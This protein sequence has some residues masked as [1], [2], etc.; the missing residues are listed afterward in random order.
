MGVFMNKIFR[1]VIDEL[2]Q[3]LAI[4]IINPDN[5]SKFRNSYIRTLKYVLINDGSFNFPV[6][7]DFYKD[8]EEMLT[9]CDL[10][11]Y[12]RGSVVT[13][14]LENNLPLADSEPYTYIQANKYKDSIEK[15]GIGLKEFPELY[16]E[17]L[18]TGSIS[19]D[20]IQNIARCKKYLDTIFFPDK[21]DEKKF[22]T[23]YKEQGV[24]YPKDL[25]KDFVKIIYDNGKSCENSSDSQLYQDCYKGL[26]DILYSIGCPSKE[27]SDKMLY[28]YFQDNSLTQYTEEIKNNIIKVFDSIKIPEEKHRLEEA[29]F[30]LKLKKYLTKTDMTEEEYIQFKN[31]LCSRF[32]ES[33]SLDVVGYFKVKNRKKVNNKPLFVNPVVTKKQVVEEPKVS[34]KQLKKDFKDLY[35]EKEICEVGFDFKNYKRLLELLKD[36]NYADSVNQ[37]IFARIYNF[38]QKNDDY[39]NVLY[40]RARLLGKSSVVDEILEI[41]E[42]LGEI[43][44]RERAMWLDQIRC[45]ETEITPLYEHDFDYEFHLMREMRKH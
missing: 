7:I 33:L 15:A 2:E 24:S 16:F 45:L 11:G 31:L 1:K 5:T 19:S 4:N 44:P 27:L 38:A 25:I 34:R 8:L 29:D 10:S 3:M 30:Y 35:D 22:A 37:E 17:Y 36:L 41:Q 12:E 23:F 28:Q 32:S 39:Y 13:R 42:L 26:I 6:I 43:P 9:C 14:I 40:E 21:E 20:S 18:K